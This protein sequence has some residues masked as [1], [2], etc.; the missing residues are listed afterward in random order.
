MPSV[1]RLLVTSVV[2][3]VLMLTPPAAAEAGR[4]YA[5]LIGLDD[6]GQEKGITRLG[7]A[8]KE[9]EEMQKALTA[10]GFEFPERPLV[11]E[12]ARRVDI[13][14]ALTDL[15]DRVTGEAL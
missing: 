11:N 7:Y 10:L 2:A 14:R 4:K 12:M 3:A 8:R 1:A 5:L 6:Y 13:V 9:V 15:A